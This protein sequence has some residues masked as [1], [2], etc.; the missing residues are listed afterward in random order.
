MHCISQTFRR[1][2]WTEDRPLFRP[3]PSQVN[4][5]I[6]RYGGGVDD[7]DDNNNNNNKLQGI[8]LFASSVFSL[9]SQ[10]VQKIMSRGCVL[11]SVQDVLYK[12]PLHLLGIPS[13]S[14][15]LTCPESQPGSSA[16]VHLYNTV[17]WRQRGHTSVPRAVYEPVTFLFEWSKTVGWLLRSAL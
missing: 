12:F 5:N 6:E 2:L 17:K 15:C 11:S 14:Y 16:Y 13:D 8:G 4:T 9:P 7:D 1:N 3:V 10:D